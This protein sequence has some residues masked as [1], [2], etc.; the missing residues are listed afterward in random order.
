MCL[1]SLFIFF[2]VLLLLLLLLLCSGGDLY[3]R[4]P[5]SEREAL[6]I[7]ACLTDAVSYL[8][9][10]GIVHR[11]L[12]FEN[13]MFTDSRKTSEVKIIDFGTCLNIGLKPVL[14]VIISHDSF[15]LFFFLL[16]GYLTII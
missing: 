13:V 12:K 15:W 4:D 6:R 10:K 9:S 1:H 3:T 11:D 8:H 14:I 5:Y 2:R 16:F 7:V